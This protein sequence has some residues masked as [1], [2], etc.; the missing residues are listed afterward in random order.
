MREGH[1][2]KISPV[3]LLSAILLL[4]TLA[5]AQTPVIRTEVRQVLV[6]VIVTDSKGHHVTGIKAS[7]FHVF[8]DGVEQ[9]IAAFS[10][11]TSPAPDVLAATNPAAPKSPSAP[12]GRTYVICIDALHT[13]SADSTRAREALAKL[14]EKE[15]ASPGTRYVLLSIGEQLRVLQT[16]TNDPAVVLATLRKAAIQPALG[17]GGAAALSS[18]LNALK[19]RMYDFCRRCAAC[20]ST[21]NARACEDQAQNLKLELD[22]QAERWTQSRRGFLAQ[23]KSAVE[24]LAKLPDGRTL[25][26]VSDGFSLQPARDFYAVVAAFLPG[27]SR[28]RTPGPADLD[29]ELTAILKIA[30]ERNVQIYSVDARG[31]GQSSFSSGGSMDASSPADTSA[32]S[33][34]RRGG[35]PSNRG[36][37]LLSEMDHQASS[38]T[39]QNGSGMERLASSTGGVYLHDSNDLLKQFRSALADG[40]EY[41]VLAYVPK[42]RTEDGKFRAITVEVS[43]KKL[44]VRAKSGYWAE[45]VTEK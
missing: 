7:D 14:F 36:G 19:Q 12:P 5:H 22:A 3:P 13:A 20:G 11:D 34:I 23:L 32:P 33:V 18:E 44:R 30:V 6:P 25:I 41:Y 10:T 39:L 8:E 9:E 15:K 42:D 16:A 37:T 24:E 35:G 21:T 17:G 2:C 43:D 31:V 40:R 28:F 1:C 26:L 4:S 29:S 27:D 45:I 38:V